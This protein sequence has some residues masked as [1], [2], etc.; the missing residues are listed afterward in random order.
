MYGAIIGDIIGSP[1]EFDRGSKTK[2]FILFSP[3]ADFTDDTVMTA[4]V[5]EALL[6]AGERSAP[7]RQLRQ[8][9]GHAGFG[10]RL[11][12]RR[13]RAHPRP[14]RRGQT[15]RDTRYSDGAGSF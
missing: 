8:R 3:G 1:F 9:L 13:P 4:A 11:A 2:Q 6:A 5:A 15:P 10:G 14:A 12:V 7:L